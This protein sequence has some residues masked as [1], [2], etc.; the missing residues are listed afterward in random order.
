MDDGYVW[1]VIG[2]LTLATAFARCALWLVGHRVSIPPRVQDMLRYAPAC[3]LAAIIA[4]DVMLDARGGIVLDPANPKLLAAGAAVAYYLWRR[5][6]L[7]TI[8]IGMLV[9]TV[10]RVSHVFGNLG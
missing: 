1:A 4:P 5:N 2:A 8:I 3:A 9:F 6:M 10:L 7:Q